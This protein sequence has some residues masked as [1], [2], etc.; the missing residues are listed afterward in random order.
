M[1]LGVQSVFW[2]E[3]LMLVW[4][5]IIHGF[6]WTFELIVDV[7][8]KIYDVAIQSVECLST[9]ACKG[10][11]KLFMFLISCIFYIA[12]YFK[13]V[14]FVSSFT[15]VKLLGILDDDEEFKQMDWGCKK[16]IPIPTSATEYA[17]RLSREVIRD[18]YSVFGL[19]SDCSDDDIKRNYKRLVALVSPEKC[20]IEAVDEIFFLVT[21][22]FEAIG[23]QEAR[24]DYTA[25]N[26][27]DNE[28]V[29]DLK[30]KTAQIKTFQHEKVLSAWKDMSTRVEEAR[31]TIFCDC[32]KRHFRVATSIL[33]AQARSC[34]R[35]GIKH[36]AKQVLSL[37][38]FQFQHV[39][40]RTTSGSKS[41]SS[42]LPLSTWPVLIMLFTTSPSGPLVR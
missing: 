10:V 34:K 11:R 42:A 14:C 38:R 27:K 16:E 32:N 3:I 37:S 6:Q 12:C 17:D 5:A 23:T 18:A 25:E 2:V 41:V 15:V 1:F 22:A 36:P 7:S 4:G 13:R 35:C 19:K 28:M 39:L 9:G 20:N 33:P 8:V 40:F 24:I 29:S 21:I 31:N 26:S 30:S